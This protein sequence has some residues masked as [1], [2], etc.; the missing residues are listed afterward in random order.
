MFEIG[1]Y[2][3]NATNGICKIT[4]IVELDLTGEKKLKPYF[5]L[6][7]VGEATARVYVPVETAE[8]RIRKAVTQS[9]AQKLIADVPS[10]GEI[11]IRNE[12]ERE[13]RYK[14]AVKSCDPVMLVSII[15]T[16]YHRMEA[17]TAAGKKSTAM[18][19]RYFKMAENHLYSELA[20]VLGRQK[21]EMNEIFKARV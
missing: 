19:E 5:L 3:V 17:R 10:I 11:T 15:K 12:K 2:V 18:D 14:E 6:V 1:D 4:E 21:N 7:P 20:F 13:L 16:L 8:K 9:E